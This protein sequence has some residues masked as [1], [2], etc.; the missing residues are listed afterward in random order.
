MMARAHRE[1]IRGTT[2]R[3]R[4]QHSGPTE[5][6]AAR[7]DAVP[8]GVARLPPVLTAWALVTLLISTSAPALPG[9][10]L[11]VTLALGAGAL[12][13]AVAATVQLARPGVP[14]W[15]PASAAVG[16]AGML[17]YDPAAEPRTALMALAALGPPLLIAIAAWASRLAVG[18]ALVSAAL[19]LG[20][21]LWYDPFLD[22]RCT[23]GCRPLAPLLGSDPSLA[24]R[25][26]VAGTITSL[27]AAAAAAITLR[28]SVSRLILLALAVAATAVRVA[29]SPALGAEQ[30]SGAAQVALGVAGAVIGGAL[31]VEALKALRERSRVRELVDSIEEADAPDELERR[32]RRLVGDDSLRLALP[33]TGGYVLLDGNP[34]PASLT[35]LSHLTVDD[36]PVAVL[37]GDHPG[38][39]C[40]PAARARPLGGVDPRAR[41]SPRPGRRG[42]GSVPHR[43]GRHGGAR[44]ARARA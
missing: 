10:P 44:P 27:V 7:L 12:L 40:T 5:P 23:V 34:A 3:A 2:G 42:L 4:P 29:Q 33:T 8:A 11:A 16:L 38:A 9:R 18:I 21:L 43:D 39:W 24:D 36:E 14:A 22:A 37:L 35:V 15:A 13:L 28:R 6:S 31:V 32:L 26:A 20:R 41:A 30:A 19:G 17:R 25:L 1:R